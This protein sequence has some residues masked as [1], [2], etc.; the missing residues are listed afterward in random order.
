MSTQ[1][2]YKGRAVVAFESGTAILHTNGEKFEG[3]LEIMSTGGGGDKFKSMVNG[4][5]TE[6]T[7]EDL[8]GVTKMRAYAFAGANLSKGVTL[9][10][11]ITAI[12]NQAFMYTSLPYINIGD[13]V[14]TIGSSAFVGCG[15]LTEVSIG[16]G[17]TKI[18]S[19]CF[20]NCSKLKKLTCYATTPPTLGANA[21]NNVPLDCMIYVPKESVSA[22]KSATNWAA[23]AGLIVPIG[24]VAPE[25]VTVHIISEAIGEIEQH[26]MAKGK[27]WYNAVNDEDAPT[28]DGATPVFSCASETAPVY[29]SEQNLYID[30][31][32]TESQLLTGN[33]LIQDEMNVYLN[34]M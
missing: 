14:K 16:S 4:S 20:S 5:I 32:R 18:D 28:F 13:A 34:D 10:D 31:E 26:Q 6:V 21:F 23:R 22:Y 9:P 1:I 2:K 29:Y 12:S 8:E 11:S 3:D 24:Y 33:L 15:S 19:A 30:E 7:A 25:T 27:T 17:V